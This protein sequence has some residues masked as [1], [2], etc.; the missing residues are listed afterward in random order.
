MDNLEYNL[1]NQDDCKSVSLSSQQPNPGDKLPPKKKKPAST[2]L[3]ICAVIAIALL[4]AGAIF[5][6]AALKEDK[7][8][9]QQ[10]EEN[11]Q[12]E[13]VRI[14]TGYGWWEGT[15]KYGIPEGN[16]TMHFEKQVLV[17]QFDPNHNIA[18]PGEYI[19]GEYSGGQLVNGT[20]Y[21]KDGSSVF[22]KTINH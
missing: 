16:G 6:Y 13:N 15:E 5:T 7:P 14:P 22:I 9:I 8:A 10:T 18:Q 3:A 12:T 21:K 4:I 17:S 19:I 20:L 1:E 11:L 2:I